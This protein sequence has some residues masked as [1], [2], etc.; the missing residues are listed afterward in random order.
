MRNAGWIVAVGRGRRADSKATERTNERKNETNKLRE[1][2][3]FWTDEAASAGKM[4]MR[5]EREE[6]PSNPHIWVVKYVW[7][8]RWCRPLKVQEMSLTD[9]YV[10]LYYDEGVCLARSVF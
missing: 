2:R 9:A 3:K 10:R 7:L 4:R 6:R 8:W 5:K 1:G